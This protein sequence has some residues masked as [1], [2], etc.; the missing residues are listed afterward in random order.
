MGLTAPKYSGGDSKFEKRDPVPQGMHHAVCYSVVDLGT[1]PN[2][3]PGAKP[4]ATRR[5][6][7]IT[8]EL[9]DIRM[10]WE[11]DGETNDMPRV[12]SKEYTLSMSEKANL[13]KDLNTWKGTVLSDDDAYKVDILDLVGVNATLQ[14][15]H[16]LAKS[17]GNPYAIV[18]SVLPLMP[19]TEPRMAENGHMSFSFD[20]AMANGDGIPEAVPQWVQDKMAGAMEMKLSHNPPDD[21]VN[22]ENPE[23]SGF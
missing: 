23:N 17:T 9:P 16:K 5:L 10:E 22:T 18:T 2:D 7:M 21:N 1:H 11:K 12:I 20:D 14:V 19:N 15:S 13:R 3:F 6:V 8:W 4:G